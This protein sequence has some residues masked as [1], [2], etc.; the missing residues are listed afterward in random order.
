MPCDEP[1][2][3]RPASATE[4]FWACNGLALQGFGGVLAVAQRELV[5]RRRWLTRE[6][7]VER[8]STSQILPGPNI[9]NL[10]LAL[11]YGYF[12]VRGSLAA[13]A[14][15]LCFPL[16]IVL[17]LAGVYSRFAA[18]PL[19]AGA[20]RGMGCVAAG[21]LLATAAKLIGSLKGNALGLTLCLAIAGLGFAAIA[22]LRWPLVAVLGALGSGAVVLAWFKSPAP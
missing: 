5:E 22:W 13:M 16:L 21:L 4:L 20:L 1:A 2:L 15:L 19:L 12:G 11:G 3:A 8:L 7:F 18:E 10:G 6:Q 9:V 17:V 14:G